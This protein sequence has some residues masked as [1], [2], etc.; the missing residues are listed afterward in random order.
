[1]KYYGWSILFWLH[2]L[3]S[4]MCTFTLPGIIDVTVGMSL[5]LY[6]GYLKIN[7]GHFSLT[8]L[9]IFSLFYFMIAFKISMFILET[10]LILMQI[11]TMFEILKNALITWCKPIKNK[12][13]LCFIY[14][15]YMTRE[16]LRHS[17]YS[18]VLSQA[19]MITQ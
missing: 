19:P 2:P 6:L 9:F 14:C 12:F 15:L 5:V 17:P 4:Q 7:H 13:I 1:M 18:P 8:S 16:F 10:F 11:A 3:S